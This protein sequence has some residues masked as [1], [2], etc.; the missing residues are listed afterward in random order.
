[1]SDIATDSKCAID[2]QDDSQPPPAAGEQ[3][4]SAGTPSWPLDAWRTVSRATRSNPASPI[5]P[6]RG[7]AAVSSL[8]AILA[9]DHAAATASAHL[10][11]VRQALGIPLLAPQSQAVH[12]FRTAIRTAIRE[13]WKLGCD[14]RLKEPLWRLAVD[15]IPGGRC[16]QWRCPCAPTQ[17]GSPLL[18]LSL[19]L[20]T[21]RS[22]GS[23]PR[24][25]TFPPP[26]TDLADPVAGGRPVSPVRL[27]GSWL[28]CVPAPSGRVAALLSFPGLAVRAAEFFCCCF[29]WLP[30]AGPLFSLLVSCAA[31]FGFS[32]AL[33]AECPPV[34]V[35]WS[36][37]AL[38]LVRLLPRFGLPGCPPP[39]AAAPVCN[40]P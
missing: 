22:S 16:R 15:A 17:L 14:N 34:L 28:R 9:A 18:W 1:M 19:P 20:A 40:E 2:C 36:S 25:L 12:T 30:A 23:A 38:S 7:T 33:R 24:C 32:C 11:F 6:A 29:V 10:R 5:V 37:L 26:R 21:L 35:S 8:T 13:A 3:T 27:G 4:P 39:A 31:P